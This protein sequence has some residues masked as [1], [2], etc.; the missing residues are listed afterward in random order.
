MR[1]QARQARLREPGP[2]GPD[3]RIRGFLEGQFDAVHAPIMPDLR[4][5]LPPAGAAMITA[6]TSSVAFR[7]SPE[8]CAAGNALP[9]RAGEPGGG[10][11]SL[12]PSGSFIVASP[13]P[14]QAALVGRSSAARCPP[15]HACV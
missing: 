8:V 15:W 1:D 7:L 11:L 9:Q 4:V 6:L 10:E 2:I 14:D 12:S 13:A 3:E 5:R